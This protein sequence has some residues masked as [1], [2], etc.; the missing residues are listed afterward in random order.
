MESRKRAIFF[1]FASAIV[2]TT[3]Y[4]CVLFVFFEF[5]I[6]GEESYDDIAKNLITG[7]GYVYKPGDPPALWRPPLYPLLLAGNYAIFD[8]S[9]LPVIIVQVLLNGVTCSLIYL[10]A[11]AV[12]DHRTG[13]FS[14]LGTACYPFFSYYVVRLLSET[15]FILVLGILV[16]LLIKAY[17]TLQVRDFFL[18]G[19]L[20][21]LG[22]LCRASL[23][24]L[25]LLV[26]AGL[27]LKAKNPRIVAVNIFI[28]FFA[29]ALPILPWTFYNYHTTGKFILLGTGGGY[30]F[31]LGNHVPTDGLDLDQL[32][33]EKL[34]LF[35]QALDRISE[36]KQPYISIENDKKFSRQAFRE[37]M[38][39]PLGFIKML[40]KKL[41]R[42]W[43]SP[44]SPKYQW[45]LPI[46]LLIQSIIL[47]LA[48]VG[49]LFSIKEGKD[50]FVLL[51]VILYFV[52]IHTLVVST[53]RYSLPIMPYVIILAVYGVQRLWCS[54]ERDKNDAKR[55]SNAPV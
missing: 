37:I 13:F 26:V 25:P 14:A 44:F 17:R 29:M 38:N 50:G 32:S 34:Q 2:I 54:A 10:I 15:L 35:T 36:G 22:S 42:F 46:L 53:F 41:F 47:V 16:L 20:Q 4:S 45:M 5:R 19:F 43:F 7:Q 3:L 18:V 1:V 31:W 27:F 48:A 11:A 24:F 39:S 23:Q 12:F 49:M 21:G 30:N 51:L 33:G 40:F 28:M 6:D 55:L 8:S 9:D 52:G